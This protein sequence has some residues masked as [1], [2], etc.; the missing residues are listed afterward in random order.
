VRYR[1][2]K[3]YSIYTLVEWGCRK[4]EKEVDVKI[5]VHA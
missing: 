1:N 5:K 3:D 2:E 4:D